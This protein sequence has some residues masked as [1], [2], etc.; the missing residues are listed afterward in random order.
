MVSNKAALYASVGSILTRYEVGVDTFSLEKRGQVALP[1]NVQ[2][3]WAHASKPLLYVACSSRTS[4]ERVGAEHYL[5]ALIVD[6]V[7]GNLALH[8]VPVRLPNRPVHMTVDAASENVLVAFN[9]PAN[10]M[11]FRIEPDGTL[12]AQVT[13]HSHLDF[14]VFP[15]Q[16]RVTPDNRKVILVT[17]GNPRTHD[18]RA[19]VGDQQDPGALK[20]FH[21]D[22]GVLGGEISIAPGNGLQ[23][24]PRHL[25]FHPTLPWVYVSLETQNM[26]NV[27]R[28][29]QGVLSHE[30]VFAKEILLNPSTPW[31]Q[32][33]GTVHVHPNGRF[34][35]CVS[36][37]HA[38]Q[39]FEGKEVL[40]DVE[41]TI[42]VFSI[43]G[44]TG[45][46]KL[47]QHIDTG[48]ICA[49]TFSLEP[50][51]RLL[52]TANAET[53]LVKKG[54]EIR[55]VPANLAVFKVRDDG[56]LEFKIKYEVPLGG[57]EKLFWMGI[58]PD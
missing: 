46:P 21:Y 38:P 10:L 27:F 20:V 33:A 13:Q 35:Y 44:V 14:G 39:P 6:S 5:C 26:L 47:I 53:H 50:S 12:G 45:E 8:G 37:G 28:L 51:G 2:Y 57:A 52:V 58:L 4:R 55:L 43:N 17:R 29:N 32:G 56:T 18:F 48:G 11:V 19:H 9:V 36:R 25:D 24:G 34:V 49:R 7:K 3:A 42:A 41:N 54:K 22:Q 16:V 31:R 1:S 40:I 23:F 30:P 15:H